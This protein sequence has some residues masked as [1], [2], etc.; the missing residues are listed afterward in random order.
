MTDVLLDRITSLVERYPV[1][2]TSVLTAWTRIRVL[3]LLVGD[4]HADNRDDE[5]VAVLQSQLG[6]AASITLSSGGSLE[7][8]AG[9]HDRL[10]ADLAAVRT[11]EGRRSPLVSAAR[12][13]RMAAAVCRGDH[14]DLR[15]FASA[16]PD[17][18]DYTGALRLPA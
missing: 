11:E 17:G 18:R 1:D 7:A 9:H 8:A 15:L 5:A 6:L 13:H 16:R 3:S 10:A 12:A 14:A 2:E 4:L